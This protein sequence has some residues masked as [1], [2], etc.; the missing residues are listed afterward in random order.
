MI[1]VT[2]P[3]TAP[4]EAAGYDGLD[5]GNITAQGNITAGGGTVYLDGNH[6]RPSIR[7]GVDDPNVNQPLDAVPGS[8][9]LRFA[10]NAS[11][12]YSETNVGTWTCI[13][14]CGP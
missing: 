14:G 10:Y 2:N 13:A 12:L 8:L 1:T 5:F 9:Y 11:G 3:M 6:N 4:L 7:W